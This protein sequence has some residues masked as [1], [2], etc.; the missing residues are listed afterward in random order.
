[1][2]ALKITITLPQEQPE[3]IRK[4]VASRK[5]PSVSGFIQQ[6]VPKSLDNDA[7]FLALLDEALERT[8]GPLTPEELALARKA[9]TPRK[10]KSKPRT[11]A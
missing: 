9:I 11:A 1:M 4:R 3:Q 6:A 8:G 7:E 2:A 5:A 10:G